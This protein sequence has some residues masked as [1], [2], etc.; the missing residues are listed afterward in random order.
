MGNSGSCGAASC[1]AHFSDS[2]ATAAY[3]LLKLFRTQVCPGTSK[4]HVRPDAGAY[5][6]R[7]SHTPRRALLE[8][9]GPLS[10][11]LP[12]S[13]LRLPAQQAAVLFALLKVPIHD[14]AVTMLVALQQSAKIT[15]RMATPAAL[16][17]IPVLKHL[18]SWTTH[19]L[20]SQRLPKEFIVL[21]CS[22]AEKQSTNQSHL[23]DPAAL[24]DLHPAAG[25]L[26]PAP[27]AARR[28]GRLL[29][30]TL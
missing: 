28:A 12:P 29:S 5:T 26:Q 23:W 27:F 13:Y 21:S 9:P 19:M 7:H 22:H 25:R 1:F 8:G 15:A 11:S 6:T 2:S 14:D 3:S 20:T 18:H 17:S 4:L 30:Y 16:V 24:E 10:L